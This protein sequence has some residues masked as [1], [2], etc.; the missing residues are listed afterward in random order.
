MNYCTMHNVAGNSQ[1]CT[2][3]S[4]QLKP[5]LHCS[6]NKTEHAD[7]MPLQQHT[8]VLQRL[9]LKTT[10]SMVRRLLHMPYE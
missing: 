7:D 2:L 6:T 10:H 4:K 5:S 1:P 8:A 3:S 9:L